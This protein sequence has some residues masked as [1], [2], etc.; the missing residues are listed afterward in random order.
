LAVAMNGLINFF[1][2]ILPLP[3][4]ILEYLQLNTTEREFTR[5]TL[6]LKQGKTCRE[7]YFVV[8]GLA[9]TFYFKNDTDVTARMMRENDLILPANSFLRQQPSHEYIELLEDSILISISHEC[10]QELHK[11]YPQF[12]FITRT[13]VEHYYILSEEYTYA[14]KMKTARERYEQ[15]LH[16]D[17]QIFQRVP[18]KHIASYLGMKPETLSRIRSRMRY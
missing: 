9:R 2:K 3:D 11:T 13:I 12:N 10:L 17:P 16:S 6:L 14:M 15:L 18:L 1:E 7:I 8:K 4:Q 5:K